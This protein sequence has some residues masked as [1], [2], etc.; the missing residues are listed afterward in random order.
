MFAVLR[1]ASQG[2]RSGHAKWSPD[3]TQLVFWQGDCLG[4][5]AI[6]IMNP[7]GSNKHHLVGDIHSDG[8]PDWGS[9]QD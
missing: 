4:N 9:N 8:F 7:D 3:G 6:W 2:M 5:P 1:L